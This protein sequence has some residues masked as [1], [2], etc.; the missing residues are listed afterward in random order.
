MIFGGFFGEKV[1]FLVFFDN[2]WGFYNFLGV[3][4][5]KFNQKTVKMYLFFSY[6]RRDLNLFREDR[7]YCRH[8]NTLTLSHIFATSTH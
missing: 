5:S 2:F 4:R 3:Y 8:C 7:I 6:F 1:V